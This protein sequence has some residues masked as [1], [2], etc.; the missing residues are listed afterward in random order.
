MARILVIDDDTAVRTIVEQSLLAVGHEV[1]LAENGLQGLRLHRGEAF[2]LILTD[3]YMPE[4]EGMQFLRILRE[5]R[6]TVPII[7]MSGNPDWDKALNLAERLGAKRTLTKP[8][9]PMQLRAA[10]VAAL[11]K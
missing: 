2:D 5:E 10:V 7:A 11:D 3:I 6:T 1:F 9:T 8:F 4:M